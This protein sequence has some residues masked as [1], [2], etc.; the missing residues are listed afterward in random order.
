MSVIDSSSI[1]QH[2][3]GEKINQILFTS[4]SYFYKKIKR[5]NAMLPEWRYAAGKNIS[6]QARTFCSVPERFVPSVHF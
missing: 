1:L 5:C 3:M 2:A 6:F 4:I